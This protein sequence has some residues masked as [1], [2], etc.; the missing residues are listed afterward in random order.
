MDIQKYFFYNCS[1]DKVDLFLPTSPKTT[2]AVTKEFR[3]AASTRINRFP[4]AAGN[5]TK[6]FAAVIENPSIW[7]AVA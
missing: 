2:S 1:Y 5:Y 7:V 4:K 6:K 3:K